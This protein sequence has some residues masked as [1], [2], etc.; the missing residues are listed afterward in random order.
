M[1]GRQ[2][3]ARAEGERGREREEQDER[4]E[5]ALAEDRWHVAAADPAG[6]RARACH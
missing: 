4:G 6:D 1:A 2:G 5:V 3:V